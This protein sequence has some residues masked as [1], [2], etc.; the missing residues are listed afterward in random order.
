MNAPTG[1]TSI[2]KPSS[3]YTNAIVPGLGVSNGS[4]INLA[5]FVTIPFAGFVTVCPTKEEGDGFGGGG[6]GSAA[7]KAG[8]TDSKRKTR[9]PQKRSETERP[10]DETTSDR[11]PDPLT[12]E[13]LILFVTCMSSFHVWSFKKA[14]RLW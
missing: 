11:P 10:R 2:A 6:G 9:K 5:T 12:K 14:D 1:F 8:D 3:V 7:R 13:T 4:T